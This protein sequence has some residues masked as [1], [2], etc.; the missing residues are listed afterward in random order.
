MGTQALLTYSGIKISQEQIINLV[1]QVLHQQKH[2]PRAVERH[3]IL[4]V[5]IIGD[6]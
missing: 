3:Q 2:Q 1:A 5:V 6:T 4:S